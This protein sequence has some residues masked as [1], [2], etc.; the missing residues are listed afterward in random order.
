MI[1][2]SAL[3][4]TIFLIAI[5]GSQSQ[6]GINFKFLND[7]VPIERAGIKLPGIIYPELNAEQLL[8]T[9][10][11]VVFVLGISYIFSIYRTLRKLEAEL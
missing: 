6:T 7:G 5:I 2:L 8:I 9:F 11:F 10:L 4:S 1:G 3:F